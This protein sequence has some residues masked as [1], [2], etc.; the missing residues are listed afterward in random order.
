M[1]IFDPLSYPYVRA[2]TYTDGGAVVTASAFYNPTQDVIGRLFGAS[3]GISTSI[4]TEEFERISPGS[5]VAGAAFGSQLQIITSTNSEALST[6]AL[7]AGDHGI[8]RAQ[9][10]VNGA[11][12]FVV[13]DNTNFVG[14]ADFIW[15]GRIRLLSRAH[16]ETLTNEGFVLGLGDVASGFPVFLAGS[17]DTNWQA[18]ANGVQTDTGVA[19]VDDTWTWLIIA[20]RSGTVYWYIAT[21][22]GALAQVHSQVFALSFTGCR[23]YHRW[24]SSAAGVAADYVLYDNYSRGIER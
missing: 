24:R 7:A 9:T 19:V 3:T 1:S 20:R 17:D 8:W 16:L 23:R 13:R 12:D 14:T 6:A 21:G 5:V 11:A 10:I 4:C 15:T 22:A 18:V 2:A